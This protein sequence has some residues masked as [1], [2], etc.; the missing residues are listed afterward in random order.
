[1]HEVKSESEVAQL[2]LTLSDPMDRSPPG[3]SS[4][5]FSRQEDWSGVLGYSYLTNFFLKVA[6]FRDEALLPPAAKAVSRQLRLTQA[7]HVW[8]F[9]G[10]RTSCHPT[11]AEVQPSAGM[12]PMSVFN[13]HAHSCNE[14]LLVQKVG[15]LWALTAHCLV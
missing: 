10:T 4:M 1:M 15:K 9:V 13:Y 14:F 3:S 6:C 7:C 12:G 11:P 2:C 5:G 8:T